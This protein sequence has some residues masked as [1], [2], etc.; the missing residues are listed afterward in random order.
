M[1]AELSAAVTAAA[2]QPVTVEPHT[3]QTVLDRHVRAHLAKLA[4]IAPDLGRRDIGE[5]RS[6]DGPHASASR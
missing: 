1:A 2:G 4:D 6:P 5:R 3:L